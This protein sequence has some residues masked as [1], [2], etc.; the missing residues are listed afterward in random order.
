MTS[1]RETS[2]RGRL[3]KVV[4]FVALLVALVFMAALLA[5]QWQ[6]LQAYQWQ[7]RPIWLIPSFALLTAAWLLELSV[8]R[9]L[10]AAPDSE[11]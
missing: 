6:A 4:R 11:G 9:F 2:P 1:D 7:F 5:S 3:K 10:L 8:W